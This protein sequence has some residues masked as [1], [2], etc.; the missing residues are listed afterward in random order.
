MP[1]QSYFQLLNPLIFSLFA[2][3]F[4]CVSL[5]SAKARAAAWLSGSYALGAAAFTID[6]F[7]PYMPIIVGSMASNLL[8][9]AT[10]AATVIG[11]SLRYRQT[12][13]VAPLALVG[14][15][16]F[17]LYLY[18]YLAVE[19][20]S[21]RTIGINLVIGVI[22]SI[23][24]ATIAA[25]AWSRPIDRI[26]LVLVGAMA[27]QCFIR[28]WL[29][30]TF[31]AEPTSIESYTQSVFFLT[32]HLVVGVIGIAL[33]VTLLIAFS[34]ETIE[35]LAKR[36]TTDVLSGVLNRRGFEEAAAV[37]LAEVDEASAP[38]A[39]ILCDIDHFKDV[40]DSFG[41]SFGDHVIAETGAL[42]RGFSHG[43]RL[44]ARLGGE[45]FALLL[46]GQ[47]LD[48]ARNI[49]EAIRRKFASMP[50]RADGE[51]VTFAA[52]FGV[53]LRTVNEPL[54]DALARADE[55][56][57]LAK[58]RGRNRVM[59]EADVQVSDLSGALARLERRQF[60]R[61]VGEKPATKAG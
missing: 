56:L 39:I 46:P 4:L 59:T 30:F 9:T 15:L 2:A 37:K 1:V 28:P 3:A 41:H 33:A 22:M 10:S 20:M 26:I 21:A 25:P 34:M 49:A 60:R 29:L 11:L 24:V 38:A 51:T 35:D 31:D 58:D 12:A 43:G 52:S 27:A 47:R 45:E 19:G 7:R 55:A 16:G 61:R 50:F 32:L 8:Y 53:A 14:G 13:P 54:F 5:V 17:A 42:F 40:N 48:D 36:S 18:L 44:A 23:G 6:F 57:Y